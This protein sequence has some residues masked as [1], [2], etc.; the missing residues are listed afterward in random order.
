[1]FFAMGFNV[2]EGLI[3]DEQKMGSRKKKEGKGIEEGQNSK[4]REGW[5]GGVCSC[6]VC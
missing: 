3:D 5:V 2:E 1:M 6:S 4:W